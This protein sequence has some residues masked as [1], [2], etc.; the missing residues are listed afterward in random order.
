MTHLIRATLSGATCA[1]AADAAS[2][3]AEHAAAAA[4]ARGLIRNA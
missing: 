3:G 2:S 4:L 1:T